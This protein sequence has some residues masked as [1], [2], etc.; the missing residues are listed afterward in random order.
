MSENTATSYPHI[1]D[2]LCSILRT[3]FEDSPLVYSLF[4]DFF[5]HESYDRP[6]ALKLLDSA[7][8]RNQE[9][10]EIRRLA[11][12]M[13][14]H[15]IVLLPVDSTEE[16]D[17]IFTCL[18][19]KSSAGLDAP[20]NDSVLKEGY[21]TTKLRDFILEF[22]KKLER[23]DRI[24]RRIDGPRTSENAL[25]EFIHLS[26]LECRLS[27]ARYLWSSDEVVEKILKRVKVSRGVKDKRRMLH[28]YTER[29]EERTLSAMPD[30]EGEIFRQLNTTSRIYWVKNST[31]ATLNSLVEYPLTTVVLVIRPPGSHLEFELKRAGARGE[32]PLNIVYA[33]NGEPVPVTHRL[34][35]GSMGEYLRWEASA[36]AIFSR[37]YR[38]I[39]KKEPPIS[40]TISVSTIYTIPL[41]GGEEH[42]LRYF[43]DPE[44]FG[45]GFSR[46]RRAMADS[47]EAFKAERNWT[48]P[49]VDGELG[50]TSQ[51]LSLLAP[52]QACLVGTTSFRLDKLVKYLSA[53]GPHTY[54]KDGLGVEY[55]ELEAKQFLDEVLDEVLGVFVP[56]E[57][58]YQNPEQYLKEVFSVTANRNKANRIY[59]S[60]MREVGM[61][62]GTLLGL[63]G[64]TRGESFVGRNVGL[65]AAW[66][67]GEWTVK[68]IFMDHDDM[69]IAGKNATEFHPR[70]ILPAIA[71]DELYVFGGIYCGQR[72]TGNVEYLSEIYRVDEE[73][74]HEGTR[75][76]LEALQ[77]AH[78]QT[79]K[80]LATNPQ[81]RAYFNESFLERLSDWDSVVASYLAAKS[82]PAAMATWRAET[83][84]L[85]R[86]RGHEAWMIN[87]YLCAVDCFDFL[88]V[89]YP[90]LF[91][92]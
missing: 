53:D 52:G 42:I 34:H 90:F 76:I 15:Q 47:I 12:L 44:S 23:Q 6:Y 22:R 62:W 66:E 89:K 16:F 54:F 37:I 79:Q 36:A 84:N 51:F 65:K 10:F 39:H 33:R 4:D 29:E 40:K 43:T 46:M 1:P 21:S 35:A 73:V 38:M 69:D 50:L 58:D 18:N 77:S 26:R 91:R 92:R 64:F 5:A 74:N 48:P 71:D 20:L 57:V 11:V 9:L 14:E 59:L 27:L 75:I 78:K 60:L 67:N 70:A 17:F 8:G 45:D 85:L 24:W 49:Q 56:P 3:E 86:S 87:D 32:K 2:P 19:I 13:L 88:F 82:D 80:E 72:I 55:S 7:S 68:I 31:S 61:F 83:Q 25:R 63:K 81:L 41:N 28:P 30:F